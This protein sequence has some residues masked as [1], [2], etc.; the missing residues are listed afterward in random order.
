MNHNSRTTRTAALAA[1]LSLAMVSA[2]CGSKATTSTAGSGASIKPVTIADKGFT[3]SRV[4]T[5][6]YRQALESA[7]FPVTV[8]S[9]T[10]TALADGA[11]R[12]GEIDMYSEYTG[13]ILTSL[14]QETAPPTEVA[15][16]VAE[17]KAKYASAGLTVLDAAP[18]N[19]DNEVACTKDAVAKYTLTDLSSLAKASPEINYS[20]NP[21]HT[22]RPDGLPLLE[23]EYGIKFKSVVTVDIGLRYKPIEEGKAQCVYAFGTDP[24]VASNN[25]VVL[26]D[27]KGKFQGAPYH[28]IPVVSQKYLSAATPQF[29]ETINRVSAT[30]TSEEVR[31]MNASVDL[32]KLDPDQVAKAFLVAKALVKS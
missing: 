17:I 4:V 5:Q 27:D 30:L 21:E 13:T 20:A 26:K 19:N 32:D 16:Q 24:K 8:K 3:E 22:T 15:A 18:F 25:L 10:S 12:K 29:A 31:K 7:G 28:G 1:G 23:N 9:L 2:A 14:L 11:I 6:V